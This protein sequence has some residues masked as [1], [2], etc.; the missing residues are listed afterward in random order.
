[1]NDEINAEVNA[2]VNAE[3]NNSVDVNK[4]NSG[5]N[6][7]MVSVG[8]L[9]QHPISLEIY[10]ETESVEDIIESV[11]QYGIISPIA[12]KSDGTI[13]SGHRR[14]RA[15]CEVGMDKVP[16][17]VAADFETEEEEH[18]FIV[19]ANKA[20]VKTASQVLKEGSKL[21]EAFEALAK[22]NRTARIKSI[23]LQS[24]CNTA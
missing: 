8:E 9:R 17:Y 19:E 12:V 16:C 18:V 15:A 10:G 14:Y 23:D 13:L 11:R 5:M 4:G 22:K 7:K 6:I 3:T 1:M 21:Q 2:E 24:K 20:R